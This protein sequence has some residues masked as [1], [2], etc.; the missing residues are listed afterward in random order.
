M[1]IVHFRFVQ[2]HVFFAYRLAFSAI[3]RNIMTLNLLHTKIFTYTVGILLIDVICAEYFRLG[4]KR[5]YEILFGKSHMYTHLQ[6]HV[7]THSQY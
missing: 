5:M 7:R 4:G 1:C 2:H 6:M 3:T